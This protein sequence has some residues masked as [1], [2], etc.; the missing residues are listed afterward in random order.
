MIPIVDDDAQTRKNARHAPGTASTSVLEAE[1]GA[2]ALRMLYND[3]PDL[4]LID[5]DAEMSWI[6]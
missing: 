2:D 5:I 6:T 3:R 1:N 4:I